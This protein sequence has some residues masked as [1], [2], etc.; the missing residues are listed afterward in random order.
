MTP[1]YSLDELEV[2]FPPVQPATVATAAD[3]FSNVVALFGERPA[4][5]GSYPYLPDMLAAAQGGLPT[6]N[7]FDEIDSAQQRELL[8]AIASHQ[9]MVAAANQP[10]D[11]WL[12]L[13]FSFADA[14]HRGAT[15]AR[16]IALAWCKTSARFQSEVDFNRDWNSFNTRPGGITVATLLDAAEK[17]GFDLE[18]WRQ[19]AGA[20]GAVA[21]ATTVVLSAPAMPA[22]TVVNGVDPWDAT[23]GWALDDRIEF[24]YGG[25][26]ARGFVTLL[27]AGGGTGKS[28][29]MMATAACCALGRSLLGEDVLGQ[30]RVLYINLEDS[31]MK[32]RRGLK[33]C[34]IHYQINEQ[35]LDGW[36]FLAG[37]DDVGSAM[38]GGLRLIK[39]DPKTRQGS[40]NETAVQ[41]LLSEITR[42]HIDILMLDPFSRLLQGNENATEV[43][44]QLME[45]LTLLAVE[46]DIAI[47]IAQHV[48]KGG[49]G[50]AGDGVAALRGSSAISDSARNAYGLSKTPPEEMIRIGAISASGGG[51]IS[52]DNLKNNL[53][54]LDDRSYYHTVSVRLPGG[55][56]KKDPRQVERGRWT[57]TIQRFLPVPIS[58]RID[59]TMRNSAMAAIDAGTTDK[60]GAPVPFGPATNSA[61]SARSPIPAI[62]S[63]LQRLSSSLPDA[64]AAALARELLRDL[65]DNR[66][67]S[68]E[69]VK[70][71]SY[72]KNGQRNGSNS[73]EGL[74]CYWGVVPWAATCSAASAVGNIA[75]DSQADQAGPRGEDIPAAA[76]TTSPDGEVDQA[77]PKRENAPTAAGNTTPNDPSDQTAPKEKDAI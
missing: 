70:L 11:P 57:H 31:R 58:Q 77:G 37:A 12:K 64:H 69:P 21:P 62:A 47:M 16:N 41:W 42:R 3:E 65:L 32:H 33:G 28:A 22:T 72:K 76:A 25:W 54:P 74:I 40:V 17:A 26:L 39:T 14:E 7:W 36:L 15:G 75:P 30:L 73:G 51:L 13:L 9:G 23:V 5:W 43:A 10:R 34:A 8:S 59:D 50:I 46:A 49:A 53:G 55:D 52:M 4:I 66:Y 27:G 35:D 29:L 61:K 19:V 44:D 6:T 2:A 60:H 63:A 71:P 68:A 1:R 67:V 48:R 18:P 56:P 24:L 38:P 45:R 20:T